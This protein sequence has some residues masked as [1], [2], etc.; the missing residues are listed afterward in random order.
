MRGV[1]KTRIDL[2]KVSD[3]SVLSSRT[4]RTIDEPQ[5]DVVGGKA[6]G[7]KKVLHATSRGIISENVETGDTRP[8]D[9]TQKCVG[10]D[11]ALD[12]LGGGILVVKTDR[13]LMIKHR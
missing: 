12:R 11:D 10:S 3:G 2:V 4:V 13:V 9:G 8:L 7:N 6:Y 5:W 1:D